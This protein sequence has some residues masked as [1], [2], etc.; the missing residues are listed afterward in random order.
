MA[1][2]RKK[3]PPS[4]IKYEQA[5]PVVSTR[6]TKA[7]RS[8]LRELEQSEG[9]SMADVIKAG[10]GLIEIKVRAEEEVRR[11]ADDKGWERGNEEASNLYAVTYPCSKCGKEMTVYTDEEKKAI[12]KFMISS[13]W[14][15]G[16]CSDPYE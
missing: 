5:N 15:H 7:I 12:R 16:D 10:L 4:R 3:K 1:N 13:G 14:H 11:E 8:R 9:V 2:K 6:V